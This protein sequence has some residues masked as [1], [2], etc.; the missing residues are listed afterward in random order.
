MRKFQSRKHKIGTYEI[1]KISLS[2]FDDKRF[3]LDDGVHML[4]YFH[5]DFL[6]NKNNCAQMK[7]GSS[8]E[9]EILIDEITFHRVLEG[10]TH[11]Q[12][13]I[14]GYQDN[15]KSDYFL[16]EKILSEIKTTRKRKINNFFPLR[17]FFM[18]AKGF[19]FCCLVFAYFCFVSWFLLDLR[20]FHSKCFCKK[21]KQ[22]RNCLHN[23]EYYTTYIILQLYYC[24]IMSNI[25]L[26][27]YH[28]HI[29]LYYNTL[30]YI[31]LY[32]K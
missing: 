28:Y 18:Y 10:S 29:I 31:F 11:Q 3:V 23:L 25:I 27:L 17:Y 15:F 12:C 2:C 4:A 6:T 7:I 16:Y 32:Y 20:F 1:N 8:K 13:S 30:H 19:C 14:W 22:T 24:Y 21:N 26:Q 9:K 5:K